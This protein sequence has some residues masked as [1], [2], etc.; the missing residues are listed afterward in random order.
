MAGKRTTLLIV[1][2]SSL[3]LVF[4]MLS[5]HPS[6]QVAASPAIL[7]E[8]SLLG[9]ELLSLVW[10]SE[11]AVK[12]YAIAWGDVDNDGDLDLATANNGQ[13]NYV[14]LNDGKQ[15]GPRAA[16][17]SSE[18]DL[19][20]SLA[21]GDYDK[22][23]DLDLAVGNYLQPNRLYRNDNGVLTTT[24]VWSS[25]ES[26]PTTSVAWGDYDNDGDLDLA[27][28]NN[29]RPVRI[30]RNNNS[31]IST[32]AT[33]SSSLSDY[34]N[35]I[36]WADVDQDGDLDLAV[37]N[38]GQPSRI[39][40]NEGGA[41]FPE[42][43][44]ST[45]DSVDPSSD[46]TN[47]IA[48]G[49]MNGDGRPDLALGNSNSSSQVFC[50]ASSPDLIDF[51][52]CW[53]SVNTSD[54]TTSLAWGDYDGDGDLD[55]AVGNSE[56]SNRL[57][58]NDNGMLSANSV[59][60]SAELD[61]T[62]SIAWGDVDNDG[63]LDLAVGN[64]GNSGQPSRI[65]RNR[66]GFLSASAD[67]QSVETDWTRA[68]A[69]GDVDNDGDLDL[70][71]GNYYNQYNRLYL[72]D[73]GT[74]MPLS[75]W[76][77]TETGN[78]TNLAWGD[79]DNDGDLDLA[80][81]IEN[82][83]NRLYRNNGSTLLPAAVWF[84]SETGPTTSVAWGDVDNDGDLD[85]AVGS[86]GQPIRI[87]FNNNGTLSTTAGWFSSSEFLPNSR[88][89]AWGDFDND[90]DLDLASGNDSQPNT[91]Y[92]ND[93]GTL[94]TAPVWYSKEADSTYSI[95]WGDIDSDGDLDL[96]VGNYQQPSRMYRN[97]GGELTSEAAWSSSEVFQTRSIALG[98]VDNDG[99]L[100]LATG[101]ENQPNRVY[102]NENGVLN[103]TASW[104]SQESSQTYSIAWGDVDNDGDLDLASGNWEN[105][106]VTTNLRVSD[107][108][109]GSM[110]VARIHQPGRSAAGFADPKILDEA[111]LPI[112]YDLTTPGTQQVQV[113]A[114]YSMDG[115][116]AWQPAAASSSTVVKHI[117]EGS[118]VFEWDILGSGMFGK[119][120]NVVFR[121]KVIPEINTLPGS[122]P[123]PYLYGSFATQ[124]LSFRARGTQVQVQNT[125]GEP[126][127]HALVFRRSGD[128]G[129][130]QPFK[131]L[132]G[133]PYRTDALGY[134]Q[135]YGRIAVGDQLVALCPSSQEGQYTLYDTSSPVTL[136][137]LQWQILETPGVQ[138]LKVSHD[139]PL[140]LFDL[141]ISLEWDARRDTHYQE[142]LLYDLKR[143]S[144]FLY[145][146]SNGRAALGN[147]TIYQDREKW[148]DPGTDI[149]IYASNRLHPNAS[150][151]GVVTESQ[152][153]PLNPQITYHP[154]QVRI[155]AVWNR[156]GDLNGTIGDDWPRTLAHELGHYLFF[157][158]DDYLGL[159]ENDLMIPVDNCPSA[160]SD[161]Y[162]ADWSELLFPDQWTGDCL[163]TLSN[164]LTG[165]S[166]WDTLT[167]FYPELAG[168]TENPGP[169]ALPLQITQAQWINPTSVL[170]IDAPLFTLTD[171]DG[172]RFLPQAGAR[173]FLYHGDTII[174]LGQPSLDQV[175]ARG[176]RPG[177]QVCV[178]S[179][180]DG[181][182]G[183]ILVAESATSIL[184]EDSAPI[185]PMIEI[186]TLD[187]KN[188]SVSV[189]N[190]PADTEI[191]ARLYL[192]DGTALIEQKLTEI[193]G[194]FTTAF[195]STTPIPEGYLR[196][197]TTGAPAWESVV[198]YSL[199]GSPA[200][201]W[202]RAAPSSSTDGHVVLFG[203]NLQF[204][205]GEF[206][207]VQ[208]VVNPP[209]IPDWATLT[210]NVY[211]LFRSAHAPDLS[212]AVN[213]STCSPVNITFFYRGADVPAGEEALLQI[214]FWDGSTWV[215][216]P[217]HLN[218][219]HNT[220]SSAATGEGLYALMSTY[221]IPL[222][223]PG[224]VQIAYPVL[225]SRSASEV[226]A[227]IEDHYSVVYRY[228]PPSA[229]TADNSDSSS[230]SIYDPGSPAW[231]N[232]FT[233][234]DFGRVYWI[235]MID[236]VAF[237][238]IKG[239]E[240]IH[241]IH[242]ANATEPPANQQP[243]AFYYGEINQPAG[244]HILAYSGGRICGQSQIF[245]VESQTVYKIHVSAAC[246]AG[247]SQIV[248]Q[249]DPRWSMILPAWSN[250]RSQA[251]AFVFSP[252][253]F[254]W[255]PVWGQ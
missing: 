148:L 1:L 8:G 248:L 155:S 133:Q 211:R 19:T 229:S 153:D 212:C 106:S 114:E 251:A 97:D 203:K 174:D 65:Y 95:A 71:V 45:P 168:A 132:S 230:W 219:E 154:G 157:L 115:G 24:A 158:D 243:S 74:L 46:Y 231:A 14:Y 141:N 80:V 35:S 81:G 165:R 235:Y 9:G 139:N 254:I 44:W 238:P 191:F 143:A 163:N 218:Q 180:A 62:C 3:I 78:T 176:A 232:D 206:F 250:V 40:R 253:W 17:V 182:H 120:D 221:E 245:E 72:N 7:Q 61:N 205:E 39:Y 242:A 21:W 48:W 223:G 108:T 36:A 11:E 131:D 129:Q 79:V 171:S 164:R 88:S 26:D 92:R 179:P 41:L 204:A 149:Q 220:A 29:D 172:S 63:D 177:D 128:S 170:P 111:I 110:P 73:N 94:T 99:D 33:W 69:W 201:G 222:G 68:V 30:Y 119:S 213:D 112:S 82:G 49:D 22:D 237:L 234:F 104:S 209:A 37:G 31:T 53:S 56:Q 23:G 202:D 43:I 25:S 134:L 161:P 60:D 51:D 117:S 227:P 55:L 146:W 116:G 187:S 239:T 52:L 12:T 58:R 96:V 185:H 255:L 107:F 228:E 240:N 4:A 91:I 138:V 101:N 77:S 159:D 137:G 224:W 67:W 142:Q 144:E 216:L 214:Y 100:D 86:N 130:A 192:P 184:I 20:T 194:V 252:D 85:L 125:S 169:S 217:T 84:S 13:S 147:V 160:M 247:G 135:G 249:A 2:R 199:G 140:A 89:L 75:A 241:G 34:T 16:W 122:T 150:V 198:S 225:E 127:Q 207:G 47:S 28:G 83:P 38:H 15:L 103:T 57:Y 166:N 226:L 18:A 90:G 186:T 183:C 66:G 32:E 215:A 244:S 136:D 195:T 210:G 102:Y 124:S 126:A 193:S 236:E 200:K 190:L 59:W 152:A 98:D 156:Y 123:G 109:A 64:K 105:N 246:G 87:Y 188:L 70:A 233:T 93:N 50:N 181:K 173:A 118:R 196:L 5:F 121:L 54:K 178:Y 175:N 151:G 10:S 113:L 189:T 76:S 145:D 27:F 6:S 197:W 208:T 167:T 162:R 42:P